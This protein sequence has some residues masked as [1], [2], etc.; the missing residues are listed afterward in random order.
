VEQLASLTEAMSA[1][2][3]ESAQGPMQQ[4]NEVEM[5]ATA[6]AEMSQA[7]EEFASNAASSSTESKAASDSA[8]RGQVQLT[9]TLSAIGVLTENVL[10][11][12]ERARHLAEQTQ[13]ASHALSLLAVDLSERV[14]RF[15]V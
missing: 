8:Q 9:D 12:S 1:V 11:A 13:S 14:Q 15:K 5:A 6:I 7:V 2:K 10:G 4:N 3:S